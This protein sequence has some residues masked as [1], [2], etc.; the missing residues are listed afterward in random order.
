[1]SLSVTFRNLNPREEIRRRAAALYE[2]SER[3]LDPSAESNL[4][5]ST[6]HGRIVCDMVVTAKHGTYKAT[7][8]DEEIRAS[9]DQVM[10]TLEE[11]LRRA[12]SKRSVHRVGGLEV[13]GL[14]AP[15]DDGEDGAEDDA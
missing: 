7:A 13:D 6:E 14:A 4:V 1:M 10:H 12:K 3:F 8:E 15:A 2:K 5:I 9:L 11:Q